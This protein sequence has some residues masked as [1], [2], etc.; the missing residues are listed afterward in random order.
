MHGSYGLH[1][2]LVLVA[3]LLKSFFFT[4]K[5][6]EYECI[7]QCVCSWE[8][9]DKMFSEVEGIIRRQINVSFHMS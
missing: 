9:R 1:K 6:I 4:Y 5:L 8:D 2:C 3:M 7:F